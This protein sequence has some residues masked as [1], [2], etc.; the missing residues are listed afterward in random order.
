M[1]IEFPD[2]DSQT[3]FNSTKAL[4]RAFG[5]DNE[6]VVRRR[7][8]D[9]RAVPTLEAARGLPGKLEE[10]KGDRKGQFS[11]RAVGAL[12]L[13]FKPSEVPPPQKDDGGLDWARV[14]AITILELGD[15]HD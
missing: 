6:K 15:Y 13:I 9:L 3:L 8:D 7:L 4:T 2:E 12:R 1:Q 11:M 5:A 14:R 10:L